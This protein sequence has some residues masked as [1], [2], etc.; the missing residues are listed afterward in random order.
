MRRVLVFLILIGTAGCGG[1]RRAGDQADLPVAPDAVPGCSFLL[2]A[3]LPVVAWPPEAAAPAPGT[4]LRLALRVE[5]RQDDESSV[6]Y[7][8]G[9]DAPDLDD[10]DFEELMMQ[11][12]RRIPTHT[13][14]WTDHNESDP[15]VTML[16]GAERL[17]PDLARRLLLR[18]DE[19]L[20]RVEVRMP[21]GVALFEGPLRF[22]RQ[23][24][25]ENRDS[26]ADCF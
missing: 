1:A 21:S 15:G 24:P 11:L 26:V 10:L 19:F 4:P 13:P 2:K 18:P 25:R 8:G 22:D 5:A 23:S 9:I 14:E 12:L 6:R 3:V 7:S 17:A 20:L 16:E